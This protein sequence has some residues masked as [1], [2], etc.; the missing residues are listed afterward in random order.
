MMDE[1][2]RRQKFLAKRP[3][4][5]SSTENTEINGQKAQLKTMEN[6]II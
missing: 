4:T 2:W 3:W 5:T 6:K 1:V